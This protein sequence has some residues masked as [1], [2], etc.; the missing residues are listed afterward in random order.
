MSITKS[1]HS[2]SLVLV[3]TFLKKGSE[4]DQQDLKSDSYFE[5]KKRIRRRETLD[6]SVDLGEGGQVKKEMQ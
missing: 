4:H 1:A 3:H 6:L 5:G 2:S